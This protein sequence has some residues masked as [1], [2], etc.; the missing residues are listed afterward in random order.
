MPLAATTCATYIYEAFLSEDR[1]KTFFHGHSYTANAV[2]C[3]AACAS[4]DL[5]D[6]E[7]SRLQRKR[8]ELCFRQAVAR[9]ADHP[10]LSN[11]RS[12]GSIFAAEVVHGNGTS[13]FKDVGVKMAQFFMRKG[14]VVRPLG[15]TFYLIPPYCISPS[16]IDLVFSAFEEFLQDEFH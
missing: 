12:L 7:Q 1:K 11:V 4:L 15:N 13:Y 8:V 14:V 2:A 16:Q 10:N 3:A 5:L 9:L 6:T